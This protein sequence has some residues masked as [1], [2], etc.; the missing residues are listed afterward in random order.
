V[1]RARLLSHRFR[2]YAARADGHDRLRG[3]APHAWRGAALL[4]HATVQPCCTLVSSVPASLPPR[5]VP[6]TTVRYTRV[7]AEVRQGSQVSYTDAVVMAVA[8]EYQTQK[9]FGFDEAFANCGY[10]NIPR[11]SEA[12]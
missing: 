8:D 6:G 4:P 2:A 10:E 11:W 5:Q 7:L 1:Y 9:I 3:R 12:A